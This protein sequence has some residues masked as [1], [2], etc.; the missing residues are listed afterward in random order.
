MDPYYNQTPFFD[1]KIV[2]TYPYPFGDMARE[3]VMASG[4]ENFIDQ[5]IL[6]AIQAYKFCLALNEL[7]S[8]SNA[9]LFFKC[10]CSFTKAQNFW[11]KQYKN[12]KHKEFKVKIII[13]GWSGWQQYNNFSIKILRV[14]MCQYFFFYVLVRRVSFRLWTFR[15]AT[16]DRCNIHSLPTNSLH[17]LFKWRQISCQEFSY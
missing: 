15:L 7:Y 1:E 6:W 9:R 5:K 16:C 3:M 8:G 12:I 13:S 17:T 14:Y 11:I 4:M 2:K 10:C